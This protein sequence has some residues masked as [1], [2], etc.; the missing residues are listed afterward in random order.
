MYENTIAAYLLSASKNIRLK[1]IYIP[2][3][4]MAFQQ[5]KT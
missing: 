2:Q 4:Y 5:I 1:A 3:T